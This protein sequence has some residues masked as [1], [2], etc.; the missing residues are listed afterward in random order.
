MQTQDNT[1]TQKST[2]MEQSVNYDEVSELELQKLATQMESLLTNHQLTLREEG[3]LADV[4]RVLRWIDDVQSGSTAA[5]RKLY[6]QGLQTLSDVKTRLQYAMEEQQRIAAESPTVACNNDGRSTE[7]YSK[8]T[9]RANNALC[10][11]SN[12]AD[13]Q[14]Q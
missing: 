1:F 13:C 14:E 2:A 11:L 6:D 8:A 5:T 3:A 4:E 9:R 7:R 10:T 12:I